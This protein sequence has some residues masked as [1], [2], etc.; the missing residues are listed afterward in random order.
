MM[1]AVTPA[2][3]Q[4]SDP[5][6]TALLGFAGGVSDGGGATF[7]GG[8]HF[9][10]SPRWLVA[11]E[12]GYLTGGRD[13]SGF[14]VDVDVHAISIDANV[15]YLFPLQGN[16]RFTPYA[17]GG[18]G[19]LRASASVTAGSFSSAASDTTTGLN[20]GGG[21]LWQANARWAV[22]PELKIFMADGS[23]IR[24]S[25]ATGLAA[26][27]AGEG[28]ACRRDALAADYLT[29]VM[30]EYFPLGSMSMLCALTISLAAGSLS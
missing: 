5:G 16:P 17:L 27:R 28:V 20:I 8:M 6:G 1:G 13:Y 23:N 2:F 19:F 30:A 4:Q 9:A 18:V 7:G 15:H 25:A 14:G 26:D 22:R 12:A 24:F 10:V 21:A 3:A 11:G 29:I